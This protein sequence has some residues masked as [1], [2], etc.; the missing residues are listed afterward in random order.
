MFVDFDGEI[1]I[2]NGDVGDFAVVACDQFC[3]CPEY[4]TDLRAQMPPQSALDLILPECF[5]SDAESRIADIKNAASDMTKSGRFF[6]VRGAVAVTRT[7]A[8]GRTRRG[9][10]AAIDLDAYD[11]TP[12]ST[13]LIRA[14]ERTIEQRIPP[15]VTIREAID[16]ELPHILLLVDDRENALARA[17]AASEKTTLYDGELRGGGGHVRGELIS[18]T[19]LLKKAAEA[20]TEASADKFG[21]RLFA[22]V[23]DGNHSLATAKYCSIHHPT[24]QNGKALVE[25]VNIYDEGLI[26]E[27]IHRLVRTG[28]ANDFIKCFKANVGG[29]AQTTLYAP[30]PVS[31]DVPSDKIDAIVAV[32]MFCEDYVSR[33][34]G[35]VEYVHGDSLLVRD[36]HVGIKMR[37]VEKS[38]LFGYVIKN[39]VLPKKT[40]SM[41]EATEKRYY[42]EARK[43]K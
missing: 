39:G 11:Y 8:Q 36:G 25:I 1:L 41:G 23:G 29:D 18:D 5:L 20:I 40:F 15:R 28:D 21:T 17:V 12:H 24:P 38:E 33:H 42:V 31:V 32:D 34:G 2:P 27:P 3:S 13:A 4:W 6:A 30:T 22:L 16:V 14:S 19:A 26:F 35:Y 9:V 43:I 7:T 37:G 10:V